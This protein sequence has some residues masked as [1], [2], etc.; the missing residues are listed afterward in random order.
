MLTCREK[1]GGS[2]RIPLLTKRKKERT[3]MDITKK[4]P[5]NRVITMLQYKDHV[6][7]DSLTRVSIYIDHVNPKHRMDT[8]SNWI[9]FDIKKTDGFHQVVEGSL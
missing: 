3:I 9:E 5:K 2:Q 4:L 1:V 7:D 6:T 8:M